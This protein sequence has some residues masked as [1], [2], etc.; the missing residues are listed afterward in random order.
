MCNYLLFQY[1]V[2][3]QLSQ[4]GSRFSNSSYTYNGKFVAVP[5]E[6]ENGYIKIGKILFHPEQ[7]IGR[8][9]EGTFVYRLLMLIF[10]Q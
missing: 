5:E 8:G 4:S 7:V 2:F 9:C 1:I 6:L 3:K 10:Y